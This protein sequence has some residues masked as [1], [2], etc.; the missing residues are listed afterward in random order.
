[1][2][3]SILIKLIAFLVLAIFA[4]YMEA[5]ISIGRSKKLFIIR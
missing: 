2:Q 1:M 3:I 5:V 4:T